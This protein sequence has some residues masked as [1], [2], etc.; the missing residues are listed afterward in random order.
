MS[1]QIHPSPVSLST[2]LS[3]SLYL[4][5]S[6]VSHLLLCVYICSGWGLAWELFK[7]MWIKNKYVDS[8]SN[9]RHDN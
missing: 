5:F 8:E 3:Y 9:H 1:L 7:E 2:S 6:E 4:S